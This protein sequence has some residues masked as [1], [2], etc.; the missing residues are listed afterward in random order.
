MSRRSIAHGVLLTRTSAAVTSRA[1]KN[2]QEQLSG[3]GIPVFSVSI[4]ERAAFRDLFDYG[5]TLSDLDPTKVSNIEK[6]LDNARAFVGE[7]ITRLR[8]GQGT[9]DEERRVS[10]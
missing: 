10:A 4:I 3:A 7:V 2:I 1:L 5:G 9:N 6:A 8:E